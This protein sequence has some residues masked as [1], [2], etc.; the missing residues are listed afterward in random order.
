MHA[1]ALPVRPRPP[2]HAT[3]TRSPATARRCASANASRASVLSL[4]SQKSRQRNHR[5]GHA[6]SRGGE[7]SRNRLHCG[8]GATGAPARI[9]RPRRRVPSGSSM[10]P[11]LIAHDIPRFWPKPCLNRRSVSAQRSTVSA[12]RLPG[13]RR[14]PVSSIDGGNRAGHST[15]WATVTRSRSLA[16]AGL[17]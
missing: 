3:S 17:P 9:P 12:E 11:A 8:S 1:I 15:A 2:K 6:T 5:Y 10:T 7:A 14:L 13:H 16:T 4:G